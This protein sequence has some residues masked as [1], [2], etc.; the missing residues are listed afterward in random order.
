[1]EESYRYG[2]L[3]QVIEITN[4]AVL[5]P[6]VL[7]WANEADGTPF[8]LQTEPQS[9]YQD[10]CAA[11]SGPNTSV[12]GLVKDDLV[13]GFMGLGIFRSPTGPQMVAN[14]HYWYVAPEYR[15]IASARLLNSAKKWA[16]DR[17]CSHLLMSASHMASKLHDKVCALYEKMGA[18]PF[19]TTYVCQL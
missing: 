4:A 2:I 5:W 11:V 12:L 7:R 15:G 10:L 6:L 8:G 17:G 3:S 9:V 1:V 14:E 16:Q 19:E 13:V 18:K